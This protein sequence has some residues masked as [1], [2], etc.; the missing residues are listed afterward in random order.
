VTG[1]AK[2]IIH[3]IISDL[4]FHKETACRVPKMLTTEHKSKWLLGL[5]IFAVT[6]MK[7]NSWKAS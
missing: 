6:K 2:N 3:E 7:N 1:T 4:N 5:K